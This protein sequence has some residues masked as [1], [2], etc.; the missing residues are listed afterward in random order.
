MQKKKFETQRQTM[1]DEKE[2]L[3][4]RQQHTSMEVLEAQHPVYRVKLATDS[5][6]IDLKEPLSES[7]SDLRQGFYYIHGDAYPRAKTGVL[8]IIVRHLLQHRK[9]S[10]WNTQ[11]LM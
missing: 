5:S 9:V 4:Q 1:E 10:Y 2:K 8:P 7:K 6:E 3:P 11:K